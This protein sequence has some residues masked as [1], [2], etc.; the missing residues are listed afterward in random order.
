M[1][2]PTRTQLRTRTRT[3][4]AGVLLAT[5][6]GLA[7]PLILSACSSQEGDAL[8]KWPAATHNPQHI[9]ADQLGSAWPVKPQEGDVRCDTTPYNGFAITFTAPDGKVYALNDVAHDD[10]GYPSAD[11]IR[12]PSSKTMWRLRSFG[13]QVC[14]VDRAKH[15][16]RTPKPPKTP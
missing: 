9:T 6:A 15:M 12:K 11:T 3:A 8:T 13:L 5:A 7:L 14:S 4:R 16:T 10:K 2:T 1:T